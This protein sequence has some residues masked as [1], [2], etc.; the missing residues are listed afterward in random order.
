MTVNTSFEIAGEYRSSFCSEG[1][2]PECKDI[3]GMSHAV[4]DPA[5]APASDVKGLYPYVWNDP[6]TK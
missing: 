4:D 5:T 2:V 6:A 3:R 1:K